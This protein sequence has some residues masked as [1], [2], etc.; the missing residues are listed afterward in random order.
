MSMTRTMRA[1]GMAEG[2]V[3][4]HAGFGAGLEIQAGQAQ[5]AGLYSFWPSRGGLCGRAI[6]LP[7]AQVAQLVEQRD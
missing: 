3:P 6:I 5:G 1:S 2:L 7:I 4:G